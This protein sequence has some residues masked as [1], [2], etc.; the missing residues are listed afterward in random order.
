MASRVLGV[1]RITYPKYGMSH[2]KNLISH[3][4]Y[5]T[6]YKLW[7]TRKQ[8]LESELAE[9]NKK[10]HQD[11][12]NEL[13]TEIKQCKSK[14][15]ELFGDEFFTDQSPLWLSQKSGGAM[16]LSPWQGGVI[17]VELEKIGAQEK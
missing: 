12:F 3:D 11:R 9:L 8:E 5:E 14:I 10:K 7:N 1:Y 2:V 6:T 15:K 13:R 16:F 4:D 17:D